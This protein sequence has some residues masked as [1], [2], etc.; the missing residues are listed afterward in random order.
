MLNKFQCGIYDAIDSFLDNTVVFCQNGKISVNTVT[1]NTSCKV[2]IL[3][4][5]NVLPAT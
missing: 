3:W 4:P 2:N 1:L 5:Q